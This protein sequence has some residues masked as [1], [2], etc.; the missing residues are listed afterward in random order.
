ML[1][2]GLSAARDLG[3][4]HDISSI[5]IRYGFGDAV[6]RLGLSTALEKTGKVL[7]W[8]DAKQYA[9]MEPPQRVCK[10]LQDLG[11]TF[12]KLG[13]LLSTRIDLFPPEWIEEF[14]KLQDQVPPVSFEELRIQ[15]EEDLG[16]PVDTVF[17]SFDTKPLAAASIAQVHRAQLVDG[18][19]VILKIRRP[20]I[21]PT[22]SADLRLLARFAEMAEQE[23]D[24]MHH[25][26]PKELV[27]QFSRSLHKEL[28]LASECRSAER[29]SSNFKDDPDIVIP[30]VYW[31]WISERLNVQEYI[32][33][34]PGRDLEAVEE[35]GLDRKLLAKRGANAVLKMVLEDGY[36]H[37]DPHPGNIFYLHEE[38][39]AFIDFGMVGRLSE[40]RRF[41]VLDLVYGLVERK[42]NVVV[43][44]LLDWTN[45]TNI[46]T[47]AIANEVDAF[48]DRYHGI[49][50]KQ[51][52][53]TGLLMD[54]MA[55]MRE[56]Q[57]NLPPD[58]ALLVKT[59]ITLEGMGRQL[60]PE[61][62]LT[63]EAQPFLRSTWLARYSLD[64]LTKRG[65]QGVL[66]TVNL[67]SSLPEELRKLLSFARRGAL[68]VKIDVTRLD[69]FAE[70]LDCAASRLTVGVVTAALIIGASIVM[71]VEGGPTLFGLPMFGFLGFSGAFTGGIWLVFSIWRGGKHKRK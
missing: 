23:I 48:I 59:L 35:A 57:L 54:L 21:R 4:L 37:A 60:D 36:F 42:V 61:F 50:L 71:T 5:L 58:L 28:D 20:G 47:E 12:V 31:P 43:D 6:R 64:A 1:W 18:T 25:F 39:I 51:L 19:D 16:E 46:N 7:H 44:V 30:K 67:L 15:L 49:S 29:I 11:P 69:D 3:R 38:K 34:I 70:R 26:Q 14:A 45:N 53:L 10:A 55:L 27:R 62:D 2:E 8:K 40:Q 22:V 17:T 24:E 33:G 52:S 56:H 65:W 63:S 32:D 13:Q 9:R 41:Q 66:S 68:Q